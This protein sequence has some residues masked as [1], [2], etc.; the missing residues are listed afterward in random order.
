MK[1]A[2]DYIVEF[3]ANPTGE[4]LV[5]IAN[6]FIAEIEEIAEMR[7]AKSNEAMIAIIIE[8]DR[9]W[10]AFARGIDDIKSDGFENLVKKFFPPIWD[11]W[12]GPMKELSVREHQISRI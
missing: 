7:H 8:Q 9:K 12:K 10:K 4:V 5:S 6:S 11:A 3:N 1:K 2:K